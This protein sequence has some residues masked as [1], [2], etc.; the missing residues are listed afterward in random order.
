LG[1]EVEVGLGVGGDGGDVVEADDR[2]CRHGVKCRG[3]G[4]GLADTLGNHDSC[5]C[6]TCTD[7]DV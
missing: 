6:G 3:C 2:V 1:V 7:T 4:W 5:D